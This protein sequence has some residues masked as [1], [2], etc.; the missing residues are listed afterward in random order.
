MSAKGAWLNANTRLGD[1][2]ACTT[3]GAIGYFSD[4]N[5]VDMLG[6]TDAVVAH[7]PE[8]ILGPRV[9]W[10]ERKYNSR[11]ILERNPAFICFPSG[12]KPSAAAERALF[13]RS[14]F[15]R[16]YFPYPFS[17]VVG[18]RTLDYVLFKAKPGA[19]SVPI[20]T[21][22]VSTEFV[23]L[24]NAGIN[25]SM[26]GKYDSAIAA[27]RR[28]CA[29]APADFAYAYE[30]LGRTY[31]KMERSD[32]A[33][34][35][36]RQAVATDDWCVYGHLALGRILAARQSHDSAAKE[37]GAVVAL[38]P[39]YIEG[40]TG[41]SEV[42]TWA[43]QLGASESV[44]VTCVARFPEAADP[45]LRLARVRLMAGR[46]EAAELGIAGFVAR[47]RDDLDAQALLDSIERRRR[48]GPGPRD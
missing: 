3:I 31:L 12:T 21:P 24:Y 37:F 45:A 47:H 29:V 38:A 6:L 19:D 15:R 34:A 41:L 35:A 5:Q 20:E 43:N 36:L 33:E 25:L 1:W 4:R 11:H 22:G 17:T 27:L 32:S 28:C 16:G 9:Y 44:L 46:L 10:K 30:W 8:S 14:R 39:D 7:R 13:L 48:G 26:A 42:L 18:S 23:D 2:F 40:Y